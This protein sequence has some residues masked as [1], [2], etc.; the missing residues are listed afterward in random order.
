MMGGD[1]APLEA[2]L[3]LQHYLSQP[4]ATGNLVCIGDEEQVK[5]LLAL[6]SL[7]TERV[8]TVHAPQVIEMHEHP[9]KALK[10]KQQCSHTYAI[11]SNQP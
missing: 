11:T 5:P 3:G 4:G 7:E 9:T 1:Y 6:H 8:K 10:E 2:V